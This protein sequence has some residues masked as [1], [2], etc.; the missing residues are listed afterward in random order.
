VN[1]LEHLP[2]CIEYMEELQDP[3]VFRFC[4]IPQAMAVGT[5]ALCYNN[6]AVFEGE[7]APEEVV[8]HG[9]LVMCCR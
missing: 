5:L 2:Q 3:Q 1:A 8:L 9:E 7:T 4:A 6:G